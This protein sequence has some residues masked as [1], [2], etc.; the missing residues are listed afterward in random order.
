MNSEI[1]RIRS[2]AVSGIPMTGRAPLKVDLPSSV[3]RSLI[4]ENRI[5]LLS[6]QGWG[7]PFFSG[8]CILRTSDAAP[9]REKEEW[10]DN[11]KR[12]IASLKSRRA[13]R[14]IF[15]SLKQAK[16]GHFSA[17]ANRPAVERTSRQK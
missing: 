11:K 9:Q 4:Y 6:L 3:E 5:F 7:V 14:R 2:V 8:T 15:S 10:Q 1:E 17:Q 12:A 13:P 16:L